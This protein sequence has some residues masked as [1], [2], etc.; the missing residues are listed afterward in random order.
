MVNAV[1]S[2]EALEELRQLLSDLKR[3][4]ADRARYAALGALTVD[5]DPRTAEGAPRSSGRIGRP[6][7]GSG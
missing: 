6:G 7:E 1:G 4:R 5:R 2:E 3:G